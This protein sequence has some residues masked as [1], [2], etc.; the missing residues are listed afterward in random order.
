MRDEHARRQAMEV[1]PDP[2][3]DCYALKEDH[4]LF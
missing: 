2:A 3:N 4:D 1:V